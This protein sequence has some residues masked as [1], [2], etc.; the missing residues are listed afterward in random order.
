[1]SGDH[2]PRRGPLDGIVVVALEQAVSAPLCTRHLAELGARVIKIEPPGRGDF[3]RDYDDVARGLAA[4]FVW[5]GRGKESLTLDLKSERGIELLHR[6]LAGTDVLVSNLGPGAM[7]RLGLGAEQLEERYP[8]LVIMTISGYGTGGTLD[9]KRAYDLLAQAEAGSCAITGWPGQPVKPGIPIADVGTA[10]YAYSSILAALYDRERTGRG[11]AI[12]VSLFDTV[13]EFMGYALN[14][15]LHSGHDQPPNGMSSPSV[16]PYGGYPTSD[17]ETVVLGTTNDSEWRR[18]AGGLLGRPDLA[19]DPR[20]AR[21]ADRLRHR[22]EIDAEITAWCSQR[23]LADVQAQAD[24]AGIGNARYNMPAD[25]VS[26]TH[27][28]ERDRWRDVDSPVGTLPVVLPPPVI[29]GWEPTMGAIPDIG[30]HTDTVLAGLGVTSE[31][32]EIL[33]QQRV[34]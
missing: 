17:G 32:I 24:A 28:R 11:A 30:E 31:E 20:Y 25:V 4:H 3:T 16:A 9:Q 12:A 15:S 7:G 21:N 33:R 14:H 23:T 13:V 34:I 22:D 1:M 18:L 8:R 10:M 5:V 19:D 29:S 27:L 6:L 2:A 26:H